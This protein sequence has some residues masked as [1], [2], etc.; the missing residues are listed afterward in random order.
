MSSMELRKFEGQLDLLSYFEKLAIIE[1]LVK[2]LRTDYN[3]ESTFEGE[4]TEETLAAV[5][6]IQEQIASRSVGTKDLNAF[7]EELDS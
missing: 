6:D 7:F 2:S 1:Y 4:P 5:S 3:G